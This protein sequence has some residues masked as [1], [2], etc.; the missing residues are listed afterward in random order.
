MRPSFVPLAGDRPRANVVELFVCRF[1]DFCEFGVVF[2]PNR[3]VFDGKSSLLRLESTFGE[4]P[5][6]KLPPYII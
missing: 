2:F 4:L 6:Y 5:L 3:A 1:Y